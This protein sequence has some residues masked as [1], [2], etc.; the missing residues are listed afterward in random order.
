ME[1]LMVS[2]YTLEVCLLVSMQ[3]KLVWE[4]IVN[5]LLLHHICIHF[6]RHL[7]IYGR[8]EICFH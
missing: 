2:C 8:V 1:T 4:K 3:Y 5:I 7:P 6:H